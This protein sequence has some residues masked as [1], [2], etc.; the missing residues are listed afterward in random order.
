VR[1]RATQLLNSMSMRQTG[2]TSTWNPAASNIC[3][4]TV[5]V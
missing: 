1:I 3:V 5:G 2:G 4:H